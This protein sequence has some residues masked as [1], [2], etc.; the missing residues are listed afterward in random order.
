MFKSQFIANYYQVYMKLVIEKI[1]MIHYFRLYYWI[2]RIS[3][4][5]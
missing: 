4:N 3:V 5:A 2:Y 1:R